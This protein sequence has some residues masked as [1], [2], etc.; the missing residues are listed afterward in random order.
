VIMILFL[1]PAL[2]IFLAG[3]GFMGLSKA[4]QGVNGL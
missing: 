2:M 4:L 1:F 3:P